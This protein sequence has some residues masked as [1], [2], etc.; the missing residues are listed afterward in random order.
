MPEY[1]WMCLYKLDFV[2]VLGPKYAKIC[3]VLNMRALRS[4]LNKPEYTLTEFWIHLIVFKDA[5][6]ITMAGFWIYK[7]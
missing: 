3:M 2:Y 1:T 5:K 6:I 7:C 4:V